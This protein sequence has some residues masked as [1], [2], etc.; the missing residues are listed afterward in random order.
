[1]PVTAP[2][3]LP[4]KSPVMMEAPVPPFATPNIPVISVVRL[5]S[6]LVTAP[7]VAFRNP[8]I[9]PREKLEVKRLVLDAVVANELVEV[10]LVMFNS[11]I[12]AVVPVRVSMMPV[13][14]RPTSEKKLV[15]VA[16]VNDEFVADKFVT[17]RLVEVALV[18]VAL[19]KTPFVAERFVANELVD[20]ALVVVLLPAV[21]LVSVDEPVTQRLPVVVSPAIFAVPVAVKPDVVMLP[22]KYPSPITVSFESGVVVPMPTLPAARHAFVPSVTQFPVVAPPMILPAQNSDP[23]VLYKRS[24]VLAGALACER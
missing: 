12:V 19:V 24:V 7:A 8:L 5:M 23:L 20:V 21:K 6:A 4:C 14:N 22:S 1:M 9:D 16:F 18:E 3:P 15:E 10:A 13:V 2:V 11:V 17:K